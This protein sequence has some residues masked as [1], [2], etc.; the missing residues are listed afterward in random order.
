MVHLQMGRRQAMS[1][2]TGERMAVVG[3]SF[4][5]IDGKRSLLHIKSNYV[6]ERWDLSPLLLLKLTIKLS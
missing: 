3:Q 5:V 1:T 4:C 2:S 6:F